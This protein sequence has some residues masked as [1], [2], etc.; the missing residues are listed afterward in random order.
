MDRNLTPA[1]EVPPPRP[2]QRYFLLSPDE[3]SSDLH[4]S[5]ESGLT[6]PEARRRLR[7]HGPNSLRAAKPVPWQAVLLDQF[8]N[9]VMLLLA[10]AAAVSLLIGDVLEGLH[11]DAAPVRPAV[12]GQDPYGHVVDLPPAGHRG[13]G[14]GPLAHLLLE[15][16][17]LLDLG[18]V[19]R[20]VY[21]QVPAHG[22]SPLPRPRHIHLSLGRPSTTGRRRFLFG[23]WSI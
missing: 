18:V 9:V 4:V 11:L 23:S 10:S 8:K 21:F 3:A 17:L 15:G 16:D 12:F 19:I 13:H 6:R 2:E 5:L 1:A 22:H 14:P 20:E 7:L